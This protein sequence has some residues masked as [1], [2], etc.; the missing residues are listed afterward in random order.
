MDWKTGDRIQKFHIPEARPY[1]PFACGSEFLLQ[2]ACSTLEPELTWTI[3]V[4]ISQSRQ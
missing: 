3:L 2:M 4:L 1:H